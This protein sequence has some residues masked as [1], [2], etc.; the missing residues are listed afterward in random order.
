MY[1]ILN[2][3]I[4]LAFL[5]VK[6]QNDKKSLT[7]MN[8]KSM[9]VCESRKSYFSFNVKVKVTRSLTLV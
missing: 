3:Y 9:G 1:N 4:Q 2:I 5:L 7:T 6:Q 8:E